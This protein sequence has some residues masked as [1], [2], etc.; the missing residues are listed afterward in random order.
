MSSVLHED[1][2]F[3][4]SLGHKK[5][6]HQGFAGYV[7]MVHRALGDYR[8]TIEDSV[9]E[10]NRVFARMKFAGM[11]RGPFMGFQ[12]TGYRVRRHGHA[13]PKFRGEKVYDLWV[14]GVLRSS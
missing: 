3:H 11:H 2:T 1:F 8:C 9:E 10:G 7:E 12:P 6:G 5:W 4:G 14:L 13:L